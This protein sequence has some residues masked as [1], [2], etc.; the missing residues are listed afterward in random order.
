M[1]PLLIA[2]VGALAIYPFPAN[3]IAGG[4]GRDTN[5]QVQQDRNIKSQV[6]SNGN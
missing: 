3:A 2:T 5:Q 4:A 1:G 6:Q